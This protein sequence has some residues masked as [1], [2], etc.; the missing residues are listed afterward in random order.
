MIQS[1]MQAPAWNLEST[2]HDQRGEMKCSVNPPRVYMEICP[3]K[4]SGRLDRVGS[5]MF[6]GW[7]VKSA[8]IV[9]YWDLKDDSICD[10]INLR[11]LPSYFSSWGD[12]F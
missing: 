5:L 7:A 10:S 6:A 8:T 3:R 9:W 4:S 1:P 2:G 11:P 12:L